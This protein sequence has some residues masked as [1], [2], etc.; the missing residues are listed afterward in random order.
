MIYIHVYTELTRA[1]FES[2]S[3]VLDC[4]FV[5]ER[6]SRASSR[7]RFDTPPG[8]LSASAC[9]AGA[10]TNGNGPCALASNAP[11]DGQCDTV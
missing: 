1:V 6:D 7:D 2:L 10:L 8:H 11:D 4:K 5:R 3:K 9:N